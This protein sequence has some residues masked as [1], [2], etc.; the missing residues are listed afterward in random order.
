M[1]FFFIIPQ[2]GCILW[3]KIP[4]WHLTWVPLGSSNRVFPDSGVSLACAGVM[5]CDAGPCS[6][7]ELVRCKPL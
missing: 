3:R 5:R 1:L 2:K 4:C 6:S 7:R